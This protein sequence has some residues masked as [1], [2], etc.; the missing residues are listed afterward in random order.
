MVVILYR[1]RL[2]APP[3]LRLSRESRQLSWFSREELADLPVAVTHRDM[4]ALF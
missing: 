4:V 1:A 3:V 2:E